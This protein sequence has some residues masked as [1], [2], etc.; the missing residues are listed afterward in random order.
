MS[1]FANLP[2]HSEQVRFWGRAGA[3]AGV[4]VVLLT[5]R[6]RAGGKRLAARGCE[7]E[8]VTSAG[9]PCAKPRGG[10]LQGGLRLCS[11]SWG[12]QVQVLSQQGAEWAGSRGTQRRICRKKNCSARL[13]LCRIQMA[14][15]AGVSRHA[16]RPS[17]IPPSGPFR[18]KPAA[19][20]PLPGAAHSPRVCATGRSSCAMC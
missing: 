15:R 2:A 19:G 1:T 3:K 20:Q 7:G 12:V 4:R 16:G 13:P 17:D 6:C 18:G 9:T 5:P 11:S 10:W 8:G 14:S